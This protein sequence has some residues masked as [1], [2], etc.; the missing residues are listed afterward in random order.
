M[1]KNSKNASTLIKSEY[2]T[3]L[4]VKEADI[5]HFMRVSRK[6][7]KKTVIIFGANWCPDVKVFDDILKMPIMTKLIKES[8]RIFRIDVG[9]YDKNMHLMEYLGDI[10]QKGLPLVLIFDN[11]LNLLNLEESRHWRTARE[12]KT[13]EIINYFETYANL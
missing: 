9:D 1:K 5:D 10:T 13:A 12:R 8:F 7:G 6:E 2:F 11:E 4:L 3:G